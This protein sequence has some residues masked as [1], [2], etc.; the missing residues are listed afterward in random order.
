MRY[1]VDKVKKQIFIEN[2]CSAEDLSVLLAEF[3]EQKWELS[4]W[5]IAFESSTIAPLVP[6]V[7]PNF[8][9][10]MPPLNPTGEGNEI[11]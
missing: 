4:E 8:D 10:E 11:I 3:K 2:G 1:T 7:F 9:L 5:T 6:G